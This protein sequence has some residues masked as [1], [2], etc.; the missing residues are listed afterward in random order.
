MANTDNNNRVVSQALLG[1]SSSYYSIRGSANL[2][3]VCLFMC[4]DNKDR[5]VAQSKNLL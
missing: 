1:G 5:K 2:S 4:S 3:H